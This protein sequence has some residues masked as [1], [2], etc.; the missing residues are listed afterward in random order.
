MP[1]TLASF[2]TIGFI[3]WLFRRDFR[4]K[5]NVTGA[6]WLPTLWV[7]LIA[8]RPVSEWLSI[9][10]LPGFGATSL[11]EGSPLDSYVYFVLITAGLCVL[12]KR[13]VNFAEIF[14]DN[15]LL[16]AFLLYC[17]ITILWSDFPFVA[18]KRWIKILGHPIMVLVILSEPDPK[19]ALLR[20][21]KRCAYVILPVS[22][23][24]IKY[25]P[26]LGRS[27]SDWGGELA[28][29]GVASGKN[30]LGCA[31][32]ILGFVFLPHLLQV[33]R[34]EKSKS[35]RNELRLTVGLL[36][37]I[38]YCLV[39]AHS[40]TSWIALLI[41]LLT[42]A[43]VGLRVVNKR[44]IGMYALAGVLTLV[45]AQLAFDI[46]G[47]VVSLSGHDSTIEG[48]GVLWGELLAFPTNP[49]IGVGFESFWLGDRPAKFYEGRSWKPTQA[50][51]GYLETYLNLGLVGL[52][53]L[54]ALILA[55]FQ[56]C[57]LELLSNFEWGRFR[58]GLLVAIVAYNWTEAAFKGLHLGFLFF[59]LIA[60][61]YWRSTISAGESSFEPAEPEGEMEFAYFPH[62]HDRF[63]T[64]IAV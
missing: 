42:M 19:E 13:R 43:L 11:E 3:G 63:K 50:H 15:R 21:L 39:K 16:V 20:V 8:S 40:A 36:L 30:A 27:S 52:S 35:R 56:K 17:F 57:R 41:G 29:C 55:T 7:F 37:L 4:E 53:I 59:F 64:G 51:N 38:G 31:C 1:P 48:R 32:L 33:L 45:I 14:R 9:F 5:P 62:K 46:Y 49:I 2:L 47:R 61:D 23:L 10:G 58:M 34:T 28:N 26:N 22:I 18:F 54:I 12:Y 25:Y 6:I 44:L 24:W 60:I